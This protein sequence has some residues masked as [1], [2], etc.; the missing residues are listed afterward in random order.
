[1]LISVSEG[2]RKID[3]YNNDILLNE[4]TICSQT[5]FYLIEN[6]LCSIRENIMDK[7]WTFLLFD[8]KK[9]PQFWTNN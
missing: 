3:L 6:V 7:N 4:V 2:Q 5:C 9:T 1:M 8:H